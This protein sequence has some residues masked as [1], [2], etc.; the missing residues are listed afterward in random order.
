MYLYRTKI[1]NSVT[2][3]NTCDLNDC[4]VRLQVKIIT[5]FDHLSLRAKSN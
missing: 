5:C 4:K 3:Y 1:S 2:N